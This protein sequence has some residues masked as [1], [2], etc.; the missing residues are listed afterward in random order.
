M[1]DTF[2]TDNAMQDLLAIM[3]RLR[4]PERGCPWDIKQTWQ[5]ILPYTLEEVYELA[6]AIDNNDV[7]GVCDELGD[8]L[9]QIVFLAQIASEQG[10][11]NFS[12]VARGIGD[13]M[14]R[15]HPHVFGE[16]VFA[17]ET[18]Q[19]QAWETIKQAEREQRN[20]SSF[21]AG[22]ANAMPAL[23]RAQKIQKR[24]A[25]VGF[26]W[27][28]WQQVVPKIHEELDE[29]AQ[30]VANQESFQRIEEEVGD[31]LLATS[32]FARMLGVD[33]ENALRLSNNKFERRF[34]RVEQ[35]LKQQGL[36]LEQ[37][38]LAQ[39]DEAWSAAKYEEKLK[40]KKAL[41]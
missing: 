19:K 30:A 12:D 26:D 1:S 21:F 37:A 7:R 27:E 33:A 36:N 17:N 15:R 40:N 28:N 14:L 5:T 23:R 8:V 18:E 10:L 38:S 41:D 31:V 3:Q 32:N 35:L 4:D 39:M 2:H 29:V 20:E 25:K 13:K 16:A 11:F 9:L 6:D 22:I 34:E 24:A